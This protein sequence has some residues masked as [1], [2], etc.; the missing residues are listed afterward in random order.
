MIDSVRRLHDAVR[1][2][3]HDNP[4]SSRT[5]RL[6]QAGSMKISKK[7]AEE[8]VELALEA[9]AGKRGEIIRESA[10]LMYHLVVLWVET[11]IEP[12]EVWA[13]LDRRERLFGIAE[14]LPK[15]SSA[16]SLVALKR[17]PNIAPNDKL[18]RLRAR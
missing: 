11:G 10:D 15:K 4:G 12:K 8:A 2:A 16:K 3:R 6:L 9:T 17:A 1:A 14:K 13:E 5:A 7:L 18:A